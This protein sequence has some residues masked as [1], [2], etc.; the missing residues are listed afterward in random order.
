MKV[1]RP[2]PSSPPRR[3]PVC[4]G[5]SDD[6]DSLPPQMPKISTE[7]DAKASDGSMSP[8]STIVDLTASSSSSP[9]LPPMEPLPNTTMVDRL[10][11]ASANA[12]PAA[13]RK[14]WGAAQKCLLNEQPCEDVLARGY[15]RAGWLMAHAFRARRRRS[16]RDVAR[17]IPPPIPE[18]PVHEL[19]SVIESLMGLLGC[20]VPDTAAC[21]GGIVDIVPTPTPTSW[22]TCRPLLDETVETWQLEM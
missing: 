4:A 15:H 3:P 18:Q 12:S 6:F 17:R 7:A 8:T 16:V 9:P 22:N 14:L 10:L 21:S 11:V 13:Q 20:S 5:F 1:A 2:I 19:F